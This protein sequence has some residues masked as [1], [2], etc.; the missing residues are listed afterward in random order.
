MSIKGFTYRGK[1]EDF[2]SNKKVQLEH[3]TLSYKGPSKMALDVIAA[4]HFMVGFPSRV[5]EALSTDARLVL[6]GHDFKIGDL[7]RLKTTSNTISELE[8]GIREIIDANTVQFDGVLSASL[9]AGDTFDIMR[10]ITQRFDDTGAQITSSAGLKIH[11]DSGWGPLETTVL[12]DLATPANSVP[13][14][15]RLY[16]VTGNVNITAGDINVQTTHLG[17]GHD[18]VRIGDGV[19]LWS[20]NASNEGLVRDADSI[21]ELVAIKGLDFSTETTLAAQSAKLPAT[22]GQKAMAASMAVTIASDQSSLNV[23]N[24]SGTVSLPTGAAT[25][26]LQ[27]TG[28]TTLTTIAGLDFATQTTLAA[29]NAKFGSLGQK[30]NAGSAPVTL[31]SEQEVILSAIKTA[32]ELLDDAIAGTEMQVD[33]VDLGGA[34]EEATQAAMSAK[35]PA[36]L[37]QKTKTASLAVTMAS[38]QESLNTSKAVVDFLDAGVLDASSTNIPIGGTADLLTT[39]NA[40]EKILVIDDIGEFMSLRNTA[41]VVLCYLPLGGGEVEVA[42]PA[43]TAIKLYS[44]TGT[45]ITAGKIAINFLG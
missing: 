28:N 3:A 29:V 19:E 14:P 34:S 16:G 33:L 13:V 4:G 43:A 35:L 37:G 44:E 30:A 1:L 45:T 25:S 24:I 22:L 23:N 39:A 8:I 9:T 15:V 21:T 42:I 20:I 41:G 6:T 12:D 5:V 36:T 17:A 32:V 26:A 18:S 2:A 11:V 40:V 7:I 31:S 38:D 10:A 27:T